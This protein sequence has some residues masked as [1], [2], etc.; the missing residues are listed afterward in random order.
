ME[1]EKKKKKLYAIR[2]NIG[3]F[4]SYAFLMGTIVRSVSGGFNQNGAVEYAACNMWIMV[5]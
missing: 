1:K 3:S 2:T 4:L 5:K